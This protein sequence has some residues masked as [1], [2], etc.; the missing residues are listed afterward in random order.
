MNR[1]A[2][3]TA[4]LLLAVPAMADIKIGVYGPYTGGSAG[5]GVSM[6]NG[7]DLAAEEINAAGG[8][9]GQKVVLVKRDD[10]AKNERGAQIM[11]EFIDKEHV[12]GVLGPINTG[13][14]DNSTRYANEGKVPVVI[15]A[16][17]GAKVNE[18]FAQGGDN[19]IF[20]I[21]AADPLQTELTVREAIDVR[22]YKPSS[23]PRSPSGASSRS[24]SGSSRSRTPT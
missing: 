6:R 2:V 13:V 15:N 1:R 7:V 3:W 4:A 11:Q 17:A 10:E 21:A 22:K 23:R 19:Y 20:R 12:A 9:L 5:M 16:S 14:A 8:I 18:Y 24:M